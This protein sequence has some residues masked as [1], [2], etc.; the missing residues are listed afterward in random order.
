MRWWAVALVAAGCGQGGTSDLADGS[1]DRPTMVEIT[2]GEALYLDSL[3]DGNAFACATCHAMTEPTADGLRRPGHPIGDAAARP[4]YKNGQL[5]SLL[6]AVNSCRQEWMNAPE[7]AETDPSWGALRTFLE[8]SAPATAEPLTYEIE[9]PPADLSGGDADAGQAVFNSS[10]AVCHGTDGAG[11]QQGPGV[12]GLA[13]EPG[14]IATRIRTSGRANSEVYPGLTGGIMPFWA[15]DRLS[16]A[17]LLDLVAW[18]SASPKTPEPDTGGSMDTGTSA[19]G[20]TYGALIPGCTSVHAKVGWTATL[21]ANFH[22]VTGTAE[23]V[24]DCNIVITGFGFDGTGIDVL[25][26]GAQNGSWALGFAMTG[27]LL[28]PGGY[29]GD[30]LIANL[31]ANRTFDDLDGVSVWCDPVGIDFGSGTFS[32]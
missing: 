7:W 24:D 21:T 23:I 25:L 11:T 14:T 13:L 9:P 28:L 18:L 19:G 29:D 1:T 3:V 15:A 6:E 8:S 27:N 16:D 31:P 22:G 26:Y 32:P 12:A 5:D 20:T 10:C 17:E 30:T 2:D 4:H